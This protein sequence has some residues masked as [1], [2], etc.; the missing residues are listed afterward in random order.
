MKAALI[1]GAVATSVSAANPACSITTVLTQAAGLTTD[2]NLAQCTTDSG[3]NFIASGA[4][5][6]APT[7]TQ[8][9]AISNST[10]CTTLFGNFQ[11][12]I[13]K[14]TPVCTIGGVDTTAFSN[15]SIPDA[16]TAVFTEIKSAS[17]SSTTNSTNSSVTTATP[18][19]AA[20]TTTKT[21]SVPSG[22][23]SLAAVGFALYAA[24][25]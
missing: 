9:A 4:S 22:A 25:H 20:P 11:T 17:N 6:T 5:G 19:T 16:L 1:L 14:I 18:T 23:V 10:A 13:S 3:Y 8:V 12:L 15:I 21:N 7:A 2:P 24:T